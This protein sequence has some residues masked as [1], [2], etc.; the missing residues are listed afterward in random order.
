[1]KTRCIHDH[2]INFSAKG[3]LLS[4]QCGRPQRQDRPDL[5]ALGHLSDRP[6][7]HRDTR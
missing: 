7:V 2:S 5:E 1:M 3:R 6:N 4:A